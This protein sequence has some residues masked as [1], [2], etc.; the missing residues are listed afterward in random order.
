MRTTENYWDPYDQ[1]GQ[2]DLFQLGEKSFKLGTSGESCYS[3][4]RRE[5]MGGAKQHSVESMME[6]AVSL[7]LQNQ[8]DQDPPPVPVH[9]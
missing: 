9:E 5:C 7:S 6:K 2:E 4:K 1:V 3:L 8:D